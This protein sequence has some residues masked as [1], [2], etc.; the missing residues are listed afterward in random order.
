MLDRLL[1][2]APDKTIDRD[3]RLQEFGDRFAAAESTAR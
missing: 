3:A 1:A 2:G